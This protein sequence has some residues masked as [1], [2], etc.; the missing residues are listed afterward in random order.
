M[1]PSIGGRAERVEDE[2]LHCHT[3]VVPERRVYEVA[4]QIGVPSKVLLL[5]LRAHKIPARSASSPLAPDV[6]AELLTHRDYEVKTSAIR[7][8]SQERREAA[9]APDTWWDY[10]PDDWPNDKPVWV[11]PE[12]LTAADAG[13]AVGVTAATIRQWVARGYLKPVGNDGRAHLFDAAEVR[14]LQERTSSRA[15]QPVQAPGSDR[16]IFA[17]DQRRGTTSA[18][19]LDLVTSVEA[20]HSAGVAAATVRSWVRRGLLT[21]TGRRGRSH[22]FVRLDVIKLAR[23]PGYRPQR[24]PRHF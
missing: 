7:Q 24:K 3:C 6:V 9:P 21:P 5:H 8:A 19:I 2:V 10:G 20:A 14:A 13:R 1:S 22:L 12:V 16:W 23:R 18:N 11:G 15:R 17:I 4:K